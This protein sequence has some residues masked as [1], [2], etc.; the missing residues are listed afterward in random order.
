MKP[1]LRAKPARRSGFSLV[2]LGLATLALANLGHASSTSHPPRATIPA[3]WITPL[4]LDWTSLES[5]IGVPGDADYFRINV[6][7]MTEAVIYTVG[8]LDTVGELLDSEGREIAT[9]DDGGE[10]GNFSITALLWAGEYYLRVTSAS[11]ALFGNPT[12]SYGLTAGGAPVSPTSLLLNGTPLEGRIATRTADYFRIEVTEP[13]ETAIYTAD[14]PYSIGTLFDAEG[15]EIATDDAG[16]EADGFRITAPLWPGEYYLRVTKHYSPFGT[17][18]SDPPGNYTLLA[19]GTPL[20]F[21]DLSLDRTPREGAIGKAGDAD[22]FRIE[23][24]EATAVVVRSTGSVDTLG[25]LL[26]SHGRTITTDDNRG[27]E[28]NFWVFAVV[29]PGEYYVQVTTPPFAFFGSTTGSFTLQAQ[30]KPVSPVQLS[31]NGPPHGGVIETEDDFEIFRIDVEMPTEA[32]IYTTG[33]F[34]S[35]GTLLDSEGRAIALDDDGGEGLNFRLGGFLWTGVYHLLVGAADDFG[36][37]YTLH[38]EGTQLTPTLTLLGGLPKEGAIE[39][40][41]DSDYFRIEISEP[42]ATVLY[43]TGGLDT[44]GVLYDPDGN[45]IAW[46]DDGGQGLVNFHIATALFRPGEYLLRV[47]SSSNSTGSYTLHTSGIPEA[48]PEGP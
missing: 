5:V 40:P 21:T 48:T 7:E 37:S 9:D 4:P 35:G 11:L 16:G 27:E 22:F 36:G 29:Q 2:G 20:S 26:D 45:E 41:G 33:G 13:V 12:G 14:S 39:T 3:S 24:S 28:G 42:T 10:E 8:G 31:L 23:V 6:T 15:R 17:A 34:D 18:A 43:S 1:F 46:D 19:E 44:A 38:V 32:V 25:I 47:L 30:G